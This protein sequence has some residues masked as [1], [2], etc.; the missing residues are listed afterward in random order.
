M[1][2]FSLLLTLCMSAAIG[3]IF[4]PGFLSL[5]V[6]AIFFQ[7][8]VSIVMTLQEFHQFN[9]NVLPFICII[10][11]TIF[12]T[13]K[14]FR[15]NLKKNITFQSFRATGFLMVISTFLYFGAFY[16][17]PNVVSWDPRSIWLFHAR[18]LLSPAP[19]HSFQSNPAFAFS[20]PEYPVGGSGFLALFLKNPIGTEN[21][22]VAVKAFCGLDFIFTLFV[23]Y[24]LVTF[25]KLTSRSKNAVTILIFMILVQF[26]SG[27]SFRDGY[28]DHFLAVTILGLILCSRKIY[29]DG[30][31]KKY[32]YLSLMLSIVAVSLKQEGFIYVFIVWILSFFVKAG[33]RIVKQDMLRSSWVIPSVI[34]YAVVGLEKVFYN[35]PTTS[36]ASGIVSNLGYSLVHPQATF[37]YLEQ[38]L[39]LGGAVELIFALTT[40]LIVILIDQKAIQEKSRDLRYFLI[41]ISLEQLTLVVTYCFGFSRTNLQ[42]WMSSSFDRITFVSH[43]T[44][45]L[46]L[47]HFFFQSTSK[48]L[49]YK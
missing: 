22:H 42:W 40:V 16:F 23:S 2:I 47:I 25:T 10:I 43:A 18:W 37:K 27:L 48:K 8:L 30:E 4:S 7:T 46:T 1:N 41:L 45:L 39:H 12:L 11:L 31:N 6:G 24:N 21:Y 44:L 36:D 15:N 26:G 19:Y 38:Y 17:V 33:G 28:F 20:H 14:E 32:F 13:K 9:F 5:V 49:D 3:A 34:L 35:V 29:T